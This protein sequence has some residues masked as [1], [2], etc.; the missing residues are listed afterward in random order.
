MKIKLRRTAFLL[1]LDRIS[2][3]PTVLYTQSQTT[4]DDRIMALGEIKI[5]LLGLQLFNNLSL[6][7]LP[8]AFPKIAGI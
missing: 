1:V 6:L 3:N 4:L 2:P 8:S 5:S 7:Q